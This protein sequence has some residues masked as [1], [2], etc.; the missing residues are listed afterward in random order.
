MVP[1]P[2]TR[3]P[4]ERT[5]TWDHTCTDQFLSSSCT[6]QSYIWFCLPSII[7]KKVEMVKHQGAIDSN[8]DI[9]SRSIL[10]LRK[11]VYW[12]YSLFMLYFL[13]LFYQGLKE[14]NRESQSHNEMKSFV[15]DHSLRCNLIFELFHSF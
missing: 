2:L 13:G 6:F 12:D 9:L 8:L 5:S 11:S 3:N 1:C 15:I 14:R 4:H 7:M 10:V